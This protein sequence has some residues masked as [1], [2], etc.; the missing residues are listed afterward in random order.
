ML[1]P[2]DD[3]RKGVVLTTVWGMTTMAKV[4]VKGMSILFDG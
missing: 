1:E 4:E 2:N 3:E